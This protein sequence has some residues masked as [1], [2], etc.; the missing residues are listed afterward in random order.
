MALDHALAD[1]LP[2]GEGRLRLYGWAP[3]TVSFGRNEPAAGL[4][5]VEAARRTGLAFVRRPTGGRAVLHA[6]E[7]TYCVVLP[8]HSSGGARS[9]YRRIHRGL[10]EGLRILGV[11]ARVVEGG[12]VSRPDAGPCFRAPAPGEVVV[13]GR[14]L[15][16]SAQARI[17]DVILQHGSV[18]LRGDQAPL[19]RLAG[20]TGPDPSPPATLEGASGGALDAT[21]VVEA[22]ARGL[23]LA[24]GGRWAEGDYLPTEIRRADDLEQDRYARDTWTW[25][26]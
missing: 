5:D 20:R 2:P 4:Y 12:T 6:D 22:L 18:I 24:L 14:K 21:D 8:A 3:P 19:A 13:G 10:V 7:V 17:G 23:C 26:R 11:A 16:G 1:C 15:V 9:V 25:R